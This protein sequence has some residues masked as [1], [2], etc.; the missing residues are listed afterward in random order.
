[1]QFVTVLE[2]VPRMVKTLEGLG[3]YLKSADLLRYLSWLPG[4]RA[5][6]PW[7]LVAGAFG[8]GVVVGAGAALMASPKTGAELRTQLKSK[9]NT[10]AQQTRGMHFRKT[11]GHGDTTSMP[12]SAEGNAAHI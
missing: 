5:I 3:P 6:T 12:E 1:M 11:N 8:A 7:P 10:L 4:R 2:Q 9:L